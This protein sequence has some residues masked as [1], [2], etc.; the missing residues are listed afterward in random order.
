MYPANDTEHLLRSLRSDPVCDEVV[1]AEGVDVSQ[2]DGC[3]CF[4]CF[5]AV[6]IGEIA[7]YC[8]GDEADAEVLQTV[9]DDWADPQ[10]LHFERPA[11]AEEGY[12]ADDEAEDDDYESKLGFVDAFVTARHEFDYP[13]GERTGDKS[14]Y[15]GS[16]KRCNGDQSNFRHGEAVRRHREDLC[17]DA[18]DHDEPGR[19]QSIGEERKQDLWEDQHY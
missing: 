18:A 14:S 8:D 12:A 17:Q 5:V 15:N 16:D 10:V 6:A 2:V 13:V 1:H 9:E 11:E 4:G 3:E 7:V 19:C